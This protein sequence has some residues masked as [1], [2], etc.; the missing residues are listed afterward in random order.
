MATA[1][2]TRALAFRMSLAKR[3]AFE[4]ANASRL[5]GSPAAYAA[6]LAGTDPLR[7]DP[8]YDLGDQ[9]DQREDS[10]QWLQAV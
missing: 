3:Q 5:A 1:E 9:D 4:L 7:R 2:E 10:A 8:G 6:L